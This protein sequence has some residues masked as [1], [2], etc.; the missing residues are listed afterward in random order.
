MGVV[1]Q[2]EIVEVASLANGNVLCQFT[3]AYPCLPAPPRPDTR[4]KFRPANASKPPLM[5]T[6]SPLKPTAWAT[7]LSQYPR[8]VRIHL[9]MI[10]C[11]GAELGYKGP[12]NAFI[13]SDNLALALKDLA[14]IE[15]KL[16]EDLASGHV[17]QLQGAPTLP[18]ICL[19]LGL[20]PKHDGGWR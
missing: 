1:N 17:T 12:S 7:L 15:K 13:L 5:N 3:H 4:I 18:Y 9:S 10:F 8:G 20:V 6:P 2:V 19:P 11:F 14:I 16:Q